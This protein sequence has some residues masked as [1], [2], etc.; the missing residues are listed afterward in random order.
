MQ[1]VTKSENGDKVKK[2]WQ[3]QKM[4]AKSENGAKT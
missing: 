2:W 3:N 1:I 4:V